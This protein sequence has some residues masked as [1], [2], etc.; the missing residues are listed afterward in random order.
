MKRIAILAFGFA[1]VGLALLNLHRIWRLHLWGTR[2]IEGVIS[3]GCV[4]F[5]AFPDVVSDWT[6]HTGW[7]RNQIRQDP[8]WAIRPYVFLLAF[9]TFLDVWAR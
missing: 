3:F 4:V 2:W 9:L 6:P 1:T 7:T 5:Y 8:V